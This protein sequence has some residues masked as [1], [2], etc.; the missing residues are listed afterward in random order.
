MMISKIAEILGHFKRFCTSKGWKTS[1]GEDWIEFDDK[2]DSFLWAKNVSPTSFKA[3]ISNMKC[4]VQKGLFYDIVKPS[5]MAWLFPERASENLTK[6]IVENPNFS[7]HIAIFDFS[8]LLDGKNRCVKLNNTDS[9]VFRE[10]EVFLEA[11]LQIKVEPL[12]PP[13]TTE[14]HFANNVLPELV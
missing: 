6:T 3:I 2:Y 9:P 4:V 10:F 8:P 11:E 7:K 12:I 1:E 5:H 14:I 13:P